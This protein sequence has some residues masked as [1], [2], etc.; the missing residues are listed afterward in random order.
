MQNL[1]L[2]IFIAVALLSSPQLI[3]AQNR[4]IILTNGVIWTGDAARPFADTVVISGD[5][6]VVS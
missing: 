3:S 6:I 1:A 2:K 5:K 4:G